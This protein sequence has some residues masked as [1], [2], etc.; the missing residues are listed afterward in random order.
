MKRKINTK[1]YEFQQNNSGGSFVEDHKK[2]VGTDI[3]IEARNNEEASSI[4][5]KLGA[6]VNGFYDY[7]SCCSCCGGRWN[8]IPEDFETFE[9]VEKYLE[10]RVQGSYRKKVYIHHYDK[11]ECVDFREREA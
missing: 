9:S 7:C 4:F 6:T 2:G 11:I 8:K 10:G 5:E 1:Y 3:L